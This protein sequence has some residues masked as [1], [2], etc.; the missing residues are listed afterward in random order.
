MIGIFDKKSVWIVLAGAFSVLSSAHAENI[1]AV[2]FNDCAEFVG[3]APVEESAA[4]SLVPDR[5]NLLADG[6]DAQL[7]VRVADCK[8]VRVGL[9]RARPG[10]VAQIG[11]IIES[12][13]GTATD[14]NTSINN[15]TLSYATNSPALLRLLRRARVPAVLDPRLAFEI[16]PVQESSELYAAVNSLW[17]VSPTWFL[18]GRTMTPSFPT[19]FLANWWSARGESQT[20]MSTDIPGIFFDF[21]SDVSLYTSRNNFIGR[22]I[23]R[24][25][26]AGFPLSFRGQFA[27]GRMTIEVGP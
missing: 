12:P 13:D 26:V 2:V 6:S 25:G 10:R 3:V 5:Y 27:S 15:Y 20:K 1:P 22:L 11:I 17:R 9:S 4:R 7:V 14:P 8:V 21:A 24:N 19:T 23:G 16:T 18:H